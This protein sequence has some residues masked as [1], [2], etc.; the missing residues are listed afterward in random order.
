[1]LEVL[2]ELWLSWNVLLSRWNVTIWVLLTFSLFVIFHLRRISLWFLVPFYQYIY[3]YSVSHTN[4]QLHNT[5]SISISKIDFSLLCAPS[6]KEYALCLL[7]WFRSVYFERTLLWSQCINPAE[8][9]DLTRWWCGGPYFERKT[10][11]FDFDPIWFELIPLSF[12]SLWADYI[13]IHTYIPDRSVA[14]FRFR[15]SDFQF[16]VAVVIYCCIVRI[17][18]SLLLFRV[19]FR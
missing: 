8:K 16:V 6:R 9:E 1:M 13:Y 19:I 10:I 2:S 11:R 3:F 7:L 18:H 17:P 15:I 5:L 14:D 12:L 4:T